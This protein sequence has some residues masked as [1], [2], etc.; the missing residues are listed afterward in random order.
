MCFFDEVLSYE[1]STSGVRRIERQCDYRQRL[2]ESFEMN[3]DGVLLTVSTCT[4][5]LCNNKGVIMEHESSESNG[6]IGRYFSKFINY[7]RRTKT[8]LP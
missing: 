1:F 3:V 7:Y 4:K 2:K 5:N 8:S 6:T